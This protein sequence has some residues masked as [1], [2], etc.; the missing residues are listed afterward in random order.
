VSGFERSENGLTH[1]SE[2]LDRLS[3]EDGLPF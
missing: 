2:V 1:I 3:A